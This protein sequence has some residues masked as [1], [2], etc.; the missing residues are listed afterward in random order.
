MN[1]S[2]IC[3]QRKHPFYDHSKDKQ[4]SPDKFH[5]KIDWVYVL[6][7]TQFSVLTNVLNNGHMEKQETEIKR[8]LKWKLE[9]EIGKQKTHQSLVPY[10]LHSVASYVAM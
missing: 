10:F 8:K 9:T 6:M 2:Y 1:Y 3:T 4:Y 7:K 5:Y